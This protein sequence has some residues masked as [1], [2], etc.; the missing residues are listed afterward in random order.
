MSVNCKICKVIMS[1]T[2]PCGKEKSCSWK[3]RKTITSAIYWSLSENLNSQLSSYKSAGITIRKS[4]S[5]RSKLSLK[6][7]K[8]SIR[9]KLRNLWKL[10]R[11]WA[12][13][14]KAKLRGSKLKIRLWRLKFNRLSQVDTKMWV[15]WRNNT[16][17]PRLVLNDWP[18][19]WKKSKV[20]V[21]DGWLNSRPKLTKKEKISN[22]D[23]LIAK[24]GPK[25]LKVNGLS[26]YSQSKK[27]KLTGWW[28]MISWED[29]IVSLRST[30]PAWSKLETSWSAKMKSLEL[31]WGWR[32]EIEEQMPPKSNSFSQNLPHLLETPPFSTPTFRSIRAVKVPA[33]I[34]FKREFSCNLAQQHRTR[35]SLLAVNLH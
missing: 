29:V 13:I 16:W 2:K 25:M 27:T 12:E 3:P 17:R 6:R 35:W 8:I 26:F 32:L 34:S 31:T 1:V 14:P 11:L 9:A 28:K 10:I 33:N 23:F 19:S 21:I 22:K 18:W 5:Q 7:W 30:L 20:N 15:L 24:R 4:R